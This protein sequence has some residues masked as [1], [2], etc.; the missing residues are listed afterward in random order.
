MSGDGAKMKAILIIIGSL[1]GLYAQSSQSSNSSEHWCKATL[2]RLTAAR[3]SQR[4]CFPYA[5]A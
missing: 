5:L 2:A 3:T 4:A 1:G